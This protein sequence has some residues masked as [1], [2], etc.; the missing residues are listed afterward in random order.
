M[1]SL[2]KELR[3]QVRFPSPALLLCSGEGST[4]RWSGISLRSSL[5]FHLFDSA[6]PC[7][8]SAWILSLGLCN[9][10]IEYCKGRPL[11]R[12]ETK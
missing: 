11:H 9:I 3:S 10:L 2:L 7:P 1:S 5:R 12:R 8:H 6:A 4:I